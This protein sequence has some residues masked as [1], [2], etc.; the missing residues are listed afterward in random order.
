[1]EK[2]SQENQIKNMPV[3]EVK[4]DKK[5]TNTGRYSLAL[6]SNPLHQSL[7]HLHW[8]TSSKTLCETFV[9]K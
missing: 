4:Q 2:S 5:K 8:N 3:W 7:I 6:F 1:M 9:S